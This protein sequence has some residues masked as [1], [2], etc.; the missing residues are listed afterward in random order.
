MT[1]ARDLP[2]VPPSAVERLDVSRIMG[3]WYVVATNYDFWAGRANTTITY[4][5]IDGPAGADPSLVKMSDVVAYTDGFGR[6][7]TPGAV[8]GVDLQDPTLAGHFQWRG[9]GLLHLIVSH[10]YV[11]ALDPQYRWLVTYFA[12]S[13]VGTGAGIDIYARQPCLPIEQEAAA[14]RAIFADGW[15]AERAG[16][17]FRVA[18]DEGAA[19]L[20]AR[21]LSE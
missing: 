15:L 6:G 2:G 17:L 21:T 19:C 11:V 18:H 14:I 3:T 9:D 13:N 8:V 1:R 20:R 16:G 4:E 7:A 12:D 10:W 5:P